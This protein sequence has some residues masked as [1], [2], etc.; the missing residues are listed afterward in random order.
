MADGASR[1]IWLPERST[2]LGRCMNLTTNPPLSNPVTYTT[3]ATTPS[4]PVSSLYVS[5]AA[6]GI[7]LNSTNL[8]FKNAYTETYNFNIQQQLPM[9][10]CLLDRLLRVGGPAPAG[11]HQSESA[12]QCG[13]A[14]FPEPR[15][16]QPH[17]PGVVDQHQHSGGKQRWVVEL[18]RDV[19]DGDE[20]YGPWAVVQHELQLVEVAGHQL[21]GIARRLHLPGQQQ[22]G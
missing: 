2:G 17:R 18:Q 10:H 3:S 4:I 22:S 15:G 7:A 19:G 13:C 14:S 16:Q 5:A 12:E 11:S 6:A 20:E 9:R 1:R 8:N 21:T